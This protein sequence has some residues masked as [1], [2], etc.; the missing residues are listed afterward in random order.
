MGR[1][2]KRVVGCEG[3]RIPSWEG[4]ER[5]E[6]ADRVKEGVLKAGGRKRGNRKGSIA[7]SDLRSKMHTETD[8]AKDIQADR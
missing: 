1:E 6:E 3:A 4:S 5:K 8:K 2:S 7:L